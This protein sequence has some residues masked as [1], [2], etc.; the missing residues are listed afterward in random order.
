[1][2][3]FYKEP[4]PTNDPNYLGSSKEPDRQQADTS[5]GKLFEGIGDMTN[6]AGKAVKGIFEDSIKR[7]ARAEIEPIMSEHGTTLTGEEIKNIAGTGAKG[8]VRLMQ[9]RNGAGN[10][11]PSAVGEGGVMGFAP[12]DAQTQMAIGLFDS[13]TK[14]DRTLP[15]PAQKEI[16]TLSRMDQAYRAGNLSDSYFYGQLNSVVAKLRARYQGWEDEIDAAVQGITGVQPA[17]ALRRSL[18]ADIQANQAAM[19]Q[20]ASSD[21]KW[22]DQ[23]AH[24]AYA[25]GYDPYKTP[26]EVLKPEVAKYRGQQ[27]ILKGKQLEAEVG[28]PQAE[29]ALSDTV[30][31]NVRSDM[32]A[33]VNGVKGDSTG[34]AF[35]KKAEEMTLRGGGSQKEIDEL[36]VQLENRKQAALEKNRNLIYS[37]ISE[38]PQG[39]NMVSKLGKGGDTRANEI[40]QVQVAKPYDDMI[41]LVKTKNFSALERMTSTLKEQDNIDVMNLRRAFP[42]SRVATAINNSFPNNPVLVNRFLQTSDILENWQKAITNGVG[43]AILGGTNTTPAPSPSQAVGSYG[44][45]GTEKPATEADAAKQRE[46]YRQT[47]KQYDIVISQDNVNKPNAAHVAKQFF[48]DRDFYNK[49]D[50]NGR[51]KLFMTMVTPEK[52]AYVEKLGPEARDLHRSW[53]INA[54]S[55]IWR[56]NSADLQSLLETKA[57]DIQYNPSGNYFYDNT[58]YAT[59]GSY[60]APQKTPRNVS[61]TI[62]SVNNVIALMKP[63]VGSDPEKLIT[64][65]GIDPKAEKQDLF[66]KRM[67]DKLHTKIEEWNTESEREAIKQGSK[68]ANPR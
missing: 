21:D 12:E 61:E 45:A 48:G 65:L 62:T 37:P 3:E 60:Q 33:F 19:L 41:A 44:P 66:F 30:A 26:I 13:V 63:V 55:D 9:M 2:A 7:D 10:Y 54:A 56:R 5:L 16:A 31:H 18:L 22:R 59:A 14:G 58:K 34:E 47:V 17:N 57:Y 43:N 50:A 6:L 15:T 52:V 39:R 25:A 27:D 64:A 32:N 67:W 68:T 24:Y 51:L 20:G 11:D 40:L 23:N 49:L 53:A 42:Q 46:I 1:M 38:D 4:N 8:K 28:S 29:A 36:V 35:R